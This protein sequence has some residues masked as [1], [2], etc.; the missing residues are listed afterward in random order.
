MKRAGLPH[1]SV[2]ARELPR[3]PSYRSFTTSVPDILQPTTQHYPAA[4]GKLSIDD[5][6]YSRHRSPN[7]CRVQCLARA[8]RLL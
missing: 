7:R 5:F 4:V 3:L 6:F 1:E 8:S 2:L